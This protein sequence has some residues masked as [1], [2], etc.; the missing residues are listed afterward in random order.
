MKDIENTRKMENGVALY[1]QE[2]RDRRMESFSYSE[3]IDMQINALD[4]LTDSKNYAIDVAA[5][6]VV[7]KK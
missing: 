7:M 4:L 2:G 1:Y 3:L 5:H 6:K